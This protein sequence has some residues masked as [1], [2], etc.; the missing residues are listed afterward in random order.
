MT[1][2]MIRQLPARYALVIRGGTSPVIARL[3]MA[4]NDPAYRRARRAGHA[5]AAL[6]PVDRT[7]AAHRPARSSC[8]TTP[9]WRP[10]VGRQS[11]RGGR[12]PWDDDLEPG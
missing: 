5:I 12:Y 2:D 9:D 8:P 1:P 4:W 11:R 10:P 6:T 7:R 3:P